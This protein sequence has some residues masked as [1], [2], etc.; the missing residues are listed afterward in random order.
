MAFVIMLFCAALALALAIP[1]IY[2]MEFFTSVPPSAWIS[3]QWAPELDQYGFGLPLI[4]SFLLVLMSLPMTV[5]LGWGLAFQI[6]KAANTH[7]RSGA[8]S[9]MQTWA[10]LPS[11]VVGVWAMSALL[12]MIRGVTGGQGY[13]LFAASVSLTLFL[14]PAVALLFIQA[15]GEYRD[16]YGDME[17]ATG[18]NAREKTL[19]F[20]KG[21]T[22]EVGHVINYSFCRLFGETMI[23]LMLSGNM[24]QIPGSPF[25]GVRTLTATI[26]LEMAYSTGHHRL[27]LYGLATAAI[28]VLFFVMIT[29]VRHEKN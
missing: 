24:L 16:E 6:S 2:G 28:A 8:V 11:V 22:S 17:I 12:P 25:D 5:M 1:L 23:V 27:A 21:C 18:L 29:R 15:Y 19:L 20:F 13:S 26:A 3:T 9:L 4:G 10:S 7:L 14:A